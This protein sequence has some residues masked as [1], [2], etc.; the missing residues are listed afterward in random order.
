MTLNG[1]VDA[2]ESSALATLSILSALVPILEA[3]AVVLMDPEG[4]EQLGQ[5]G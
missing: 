2:L 4:R 3:L 1:V 5:R